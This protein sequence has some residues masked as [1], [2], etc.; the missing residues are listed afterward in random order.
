YC[1]DSTHQGRL[2]FRLP[3]QF[4]VSLS[5]EATAFYEVPGE[6]D[7]G[8]AEHHHKRSITIASSCYRR[9]QPAFPMADETNTTGI[10]LF[11]RPQVLQRGLRVAR[12][13]LHLCPRKPSA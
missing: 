10:H 7:R 5:T 1:Q 8:S 2:R 3:V 6:R 12:K 13:V 9:C 4:T 11:T